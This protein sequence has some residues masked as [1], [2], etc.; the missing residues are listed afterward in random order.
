MDRR[1]RAVCRDGYLAERLPAESGAAAKQLTQRK[2]HGIRY[3]GRF[4]GWNIG[5][6]LWPGLAVD[7]LVPKAVG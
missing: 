1:G 5:G 3:D 6:Q 2:E 7:P 4:D